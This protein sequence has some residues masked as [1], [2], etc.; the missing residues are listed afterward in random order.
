MRYEPIVETRNRKPM[1]PNPIADW[2]LRIGQFRVLYNVSESILVVDVR[3]IGKKER[4]VYFFRGQ[5]EDL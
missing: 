3:R 5:Q 4:S 1:R 2:E